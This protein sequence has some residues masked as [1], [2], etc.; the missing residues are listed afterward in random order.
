MQVSIVQGLTDSGYQVKMVVRKFFVVSGSPDARI[1]SLM[2]FMFENPDSTSTISN[3]AT[4]ITYSIR[5]S[6]SQLQEWKRVAGI[7]SIF[8]ETN[9]E[10]WPKHKKI[11][12]KRNLYFCISTYISGMYCFKSFTKRK[13]QAFFNRCNPH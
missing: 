4:N 5:K 8:D 7:L 6:F 13:S 2:S 12:I 11:N 10:D 9:A 3:F 1:G